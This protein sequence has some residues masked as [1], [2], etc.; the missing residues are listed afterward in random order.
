MNNNKNLVIIIII[1]IIIIYFLNIK[2]KISTAI[3]S[4]IENFKYNFFNSPNQLGNTIC[5]YFYYYA[6]SIC[7]KTDFETTTDNYN[8]IKYLPN[9]IPFNNELYNKLNEYNITKEKIESKCSECLWHCDNEWIYNLWKTLKPTINEILNNA[10]IKSK[11]NENIK[12]PI[13]HFRC[14]D[15]PF[16]KHRQYYLQ[17]Y[18]FFKTALEK[19]N[20]NNDKTVI[21]M[22]YFKHNSDDNNINACNEYLNNLKKYLFELGYTCILQSKSN[23]EDFSDL[24]NAPYVISTGGSF[25]FMSGFFGNG[26]FIS[27]EHCE[28]DNNCCKDCG[29]VFLK[30]YNIH[31][32]LIKSYYDV[33]DVENNYRR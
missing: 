33:N 31:H 17:K 5:S 9:Y 27:T 2:F 12:Y 4:T 13:I 22:Y 28:E 6:L 24:F 18:S 23:F 26:Q 7:N 16:A 29:N 1:F 19:Y 11:L 25:S 32:K 21:I 8:I 30:E 20:F 10:I 15:V 14:A 3:I